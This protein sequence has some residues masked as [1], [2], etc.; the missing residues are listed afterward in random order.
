[1]AFPQPVSPIEM[2]CLIARLGKGG[3]AQ[4]QDW[5]ENVSHMDNSPPKCLS[6]FQL[7]FLYL[8]SMQRANASW[9]VFDKVFGK[10][11]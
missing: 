2:E 8:R 6:S 9:T 4:G 11:P 1:M 7:N 3:E 5:E 10:I